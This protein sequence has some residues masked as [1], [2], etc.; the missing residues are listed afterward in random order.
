MCI[1]LHDIFFS[2]IFYNKE[3]SGCVYSSAP[4]VAAAVD[5]KLYRQ[6]QDYQEMNSKIL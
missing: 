6:I 4:T 2:I 5:K 1:Y 3:V